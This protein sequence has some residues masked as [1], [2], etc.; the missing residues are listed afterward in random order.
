MRNESEIEA[1]LDSLETLVNEAEGKRGKW[2]DVWV[3]IKSVGQ[4]FKQSRFPTAQDRQVAWNR[5]QSIIANVKACQERTKKL[6]EE[7]VRESE[8]HLEQILSYAE[9]A[10][11]SSRLVDALFA[12][13]TGGSSI[14][15]NES[16]NA[17]LGSFDE[18][19]I[20]LQKCNEAMKEGWA[21]LS[22]NK[23]Q[24]FGKDKQKSFEAL[25][26]ASEILHEAWN[27]WKSA[28]REATEQYLTE[29]QAAWEARQA[30]REAWIAKREAWEERMRENISKLEDRLHRLE[31]VLGRRQSNLS[32]LVDMRDSAWSDSYRD[33]VEE[34]INEENDRISDIQRKIDQIKEWVSDMEAKLR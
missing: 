30:K 23:G 21:Y 7:K 17:I 28:R 24:M 11:P 14:L 2:K 25:K 20:E 10:T 4:A 32:K 19:K 13:C 15:I 31:S 26:K 33:R 8:Y 22:Q 12:I 27:E 29:K 34:W 16:I 9:K 5:F 1:L 3:E 18:R 6:F